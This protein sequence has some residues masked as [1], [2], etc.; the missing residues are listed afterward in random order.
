MKFNELNQPVGMVENPKLTK[1]Y[2]SFQQ[3][4]SE[5]DKYEL[6]EEIIDDINHAI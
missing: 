4:I 2:H 1:H 6:T 5:L 3:L